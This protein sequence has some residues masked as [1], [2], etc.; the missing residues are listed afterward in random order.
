MNLEDNIKDVIAKKLEDGTIEKL[1]EEQL[2]KG[3]K[4]A[5]ESLFGSYGDVTKVI[6][7]QVKSVMIPYLES[8][9]YSDYIVKLDSVLVDVLKNTAI[10]NKTMLHNFKELMTVTER[11]T[12]MKVSDLFET[13]TKYVAKNVETDDLE[14]DY[15][16]GKP[17]YYCVDVT[18]EV[19]Y[20]ESKNWGS[21]EYAVLSFECEH[22]DK[23]NFSVRLSKYGKSKSKAWDIQ[24]DNVKDIS[25]LRY[26][27][28]FEVLLMKLNQNGTKIILDED[29]GSD[30]VQ[31]EKEPEASF[32]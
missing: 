25:S 16:E 30:E 7:K 10:E 31:P 32:S 27:N 6:E 3:V 2:I 1:I 12:E 4:S 5:L 23:M 24:Y 26:L 29:S 18:F 15:E 8:Y 28:D 14:I 11:N 20:N 13:W 21:F 19:D 9:D 22:D 17:S